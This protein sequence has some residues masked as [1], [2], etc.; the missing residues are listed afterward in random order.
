MLTSILGGLV[1]LI[2]P[3][4]L[5][6]LRVAGAREAVQSAVRQAIDDFNE[7]RNSVTL[8]GEI[9]EEALA[10][11]KAESSKKVGSNSETK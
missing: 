11:L 8:P 4:F 2:G 9:E 5:Y 3:V 10:R 1:S 7:D 6:F